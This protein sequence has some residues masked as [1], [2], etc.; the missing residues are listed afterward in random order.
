M[1][2]TGVNYC[3]SYFVHGNGSN[4]DYGPV[5][6][7]FSGGSI[8]SPPFVLESGRF[9]A[10]GTPGVFPTGGLNTFYGVDVLYGSGSSPNPVYIAPSANI[11]AGG[12]ATTAQLAAPP[13]KTTA[14][15][16]VGRMWDDENGTDPVNI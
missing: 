4:A 10:S 1:A 12:Q 15:F 6:G 8:S 3:V 5:S 13:G 11:A 2:T 9:V 14:D 7:A 16:A